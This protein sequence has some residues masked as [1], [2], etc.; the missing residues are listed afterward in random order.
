[1]IGIRGIVAGSG[2]L[3]LAS[4]PALAAQAQ[5]DDAA[6]APLPECAPEAGRVPV[7]QGIR[8]EEVPTLEGDLPRLRV[9]APQE[10]FMYV[11]HDAA[12]EPVARSWAACLGTQLALAMYLLQDDRTGAEWQSVV[13]S[14]DADYALPRGD[15]VV[16]RWLVHTGESLEHRS[17]LVE[18]LLSTLPHEQVHEFQGREGGGRPRWLSE[19]HASWMGHRITR[20]IA[21][22]RAADL[23]SGQL[24]DLRPDEDIDLAGWGFPQ[25]RREALM[26]QVSEADRARMEEDPSFVPKGSYSFGP[27]DFESDE[28]QTDARYAAAWLVFEKLEAQYGFERVSAWATRLTATS[29]FLIN[30]AVARSLE[31]EFGE[32]LYALLGETQRHAI[33]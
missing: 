24:R 26:R 7:V 5:T 2:L 15:D 9:S 4:L 33:R 12:S 17:D 16:T 31:E 27:D 30:D 8:V 19:G 1:M 6:L 18:T 21:P 11:Y 20:I 23:R 25:P 28:S 13:F 3:L 10:A 29:D 22:A 14:R 32:D